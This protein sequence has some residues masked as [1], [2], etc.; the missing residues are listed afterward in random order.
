MAPCYLNGLYV[1][2]S[3]NNKHRKELLKPPQ[4]V[5][6]FR[7]QW[8]RLATLEQPSSWSLLGIIFAHFGVAEIR[9]K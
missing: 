2:Y 5:Q 9:R 4:A 6:P 3:T 7:S 8:S 1:L